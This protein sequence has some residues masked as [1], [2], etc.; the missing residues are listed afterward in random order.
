MPKHRI[1]I[2]VN[3]NADLGRAW[4]YSA[5]LRP[6]VDEHGGADWTGTVYPTHAV[7]L[8]RLAG[9]EGYEQ[10]IAVGGDGTVHEVVNGLMLLPPEKRPRLGVVPMGTGNDFAFNTGFPMKM[11]LALLQSLNGQVK[12]VDVGELRD[13]HGRVEYFDNTMGIGF[14]TIVTLRSRNIPILRGFPVYLM[15]VIQT[16]LLDH[17][18]ARL[19]IDMDGEHS[20]QETIM[21]VACNGAREGG[22]FYIAPQARNDDGIFHSATVG[23]VSQLRMFRL[24]PEFLRGTHTRFADV[25]MGSFKKLHIRSDRPLFIHVDGE[26]FSGFGTDE[27][28]IWVDMHPG[29]L[30]IVV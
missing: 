8:A 1:K 26:I 15:A 13:S 20:E 2:I 17:H 11:H 6:I 25:K 7:E 19:S 16:I 5:D 18:P 12:R 14:D 29:A 27:R 9:E 28:E 22:G 24:L 30:E 3:P 4:R 10:V 23:K 21:L